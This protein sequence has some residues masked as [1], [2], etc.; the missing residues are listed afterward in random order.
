MVMPDRDTFFVKSATANV[1][2]RSMKIQG[3]TIKAN[4]TTGEALPM[5]QTVP[6]Q[7][8]R[9]GDGTFSEVLT[10]GYASIPL[11]ITPDLSASSG[12]F[13]FAIGDFADGTLKRIARVRL[14]RKD[15]HGRHERDDDDGDDDGK[16]HDRDDDDDD[17]GKHDSFDS[18]SDN[19]GSV[20]AMDEDDD[21]D[22]IE[23][24]FD[25]KDKK[26]YKQTSQQALALARP[27]R[28]PSR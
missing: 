2:Y 21:N 28:I 1:P 25:T 23:D 18:D 11:G 3:V 24:G 10:Q 14:P 22:G 5:R 7:V 13:F 12:T 17:D 4:R 20:D 9:N 6:G 27:L 15:F 8:V 19:D 26:E 16:R